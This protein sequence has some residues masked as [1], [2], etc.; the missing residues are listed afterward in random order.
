MTAAEA[1]PATLERLLSALAAG[2]DLSPRA[3]REGPRDGVLVEA[4]DTDRE[5]AAAEP[6][7]PAEPVVSA[8]A[9]GTAAIA[10]P[11]PRANASAPTRPTYRA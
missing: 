5:S 8:N 6:L 2:E 1:L 4:A 10:E 3:P 11:T 9:S 7:D